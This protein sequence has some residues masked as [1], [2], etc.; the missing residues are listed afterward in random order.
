MND[1]INPDTP[2][3]ISENKIITHNQLTKLQRDYVKDIAPRSLIIII[4]SNT[5]DSVIFYTACIKSKIIP[6]LVDIDISS[7]RLSDL[8]KR[9]QP[10]YV[11]APENRVI[12]ENMENIRKYE[13]YTLYRTHKTETFYINNELALL[14]STSGSTGSSKFVRISYENI[15]SNTESIIRYLNITEN[16]VAIT[17]LPMS[18]TYGLS[19]INTHLYAGGTVVVT[20]RKMIKQEFWELVYKHKVTSI[21]G[22]P[23]TYEVLNRIGLNKIKNSY[24]RTMTQAGG[25]LSEELQS[26]IGDFAKDNGINFYIMYGQ[27]E[28]T[29][30]M[31]Y[32]PPE[33][34]NSK[35]G[36]VGIA[37]PG[38]EISIK[39]C[40]ADKSA[41]K[42]TGADNYGEIIYRGKNVSMG[43]AEDLKDLRKA[44]EFKGILY[45][46]DLGYIDDDGF[47]YITGRIDKVVKMFGKRVNLNE[48]E[49]HLQRIFIKQFVCLAG[50][51]YLYVYSE[52]KLE[53]DRI[54]R[55]LYNYIG[56]ENK[57][58]RYENKI[59]RRNLRGKVV[60]I[61]E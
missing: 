61:Y 36:S 23:F 11:F 28:A 20:E 47:L 10:D 7:D 12:T 25:K 32:L 48:V 56:L 37:I 4:C 53:E 60:G 39:P 52:D 58:I 30:R 16:D 45:T 24:I 5:L 2:A 34:V 46:R 22:V 40:S 38:G 13:T 41:T 6:M 27:T 43:Y 33:Y 1:T 51:E 50:N 19:V 17:T 59:F 54:K 57:S 3:L 49:N 21:S 29:A 35:I 55:E 15:K 8:V 26:C 31:T 14:L 9:Y 42:T 18:Y 44:D